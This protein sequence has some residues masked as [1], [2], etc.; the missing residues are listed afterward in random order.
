MKRLI[1]PT[2]ILLLLACVLFIASAPQDIK[3]ENGAIFANSAADGGHLVITRSP[4][5]GRNVT[6][7]LKI[8][9]KI[10]DS[11][12]WRRTFDRYIK[13][14]RHTLTATATRT[15]GAWQTTLDVR[16][17][18]TYSYSASY[19]VDKLVLTQKH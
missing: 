4:T 14:G 2:P 16:P 11:I 18:Q 12:T 6:I 5:M 13:P 1:F 17:G 9:G 3:A 15:S 7:T 19:A 10:A 8:D